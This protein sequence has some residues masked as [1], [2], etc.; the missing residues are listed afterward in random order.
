MLLESEIKHFAKEVGID[1]I[2]FTTAEPFEKTALHLKELLKSGYIPSHWKVAEFDS[3][4]NPKS[5]LP[6]AKSIIVAAECYLTSEPE[7][8]TKPGEPYGRIARYTWRNYYYDLKKRLEKVAKFLRKEVGK[9][10]KFKVYS[11]GAVAEKPM[12]QRSGLGWYG[13]HGIILTEEFGSRIVLG[14]IITNV[15][16]KPDELLEKDCGECVACIKSCPTGAIVNPAPLQ[17]CGVKLY[18]LDVSKCLQY[19]TNRRGVLPVEYREV[20]GNRLYG[21]TTCQDVCPKNAGVLP[22]ERKP[23]Y[24]E[25][26]SCLPLIPLL[27]MT[28][29]EYRTKY[30]NNQMTTRWIHFDCIKRNAVIALGNIGDSVAVPVL[31]EMLKDKNPMVRTHATWALEKI[32]KKRKVEL[33]RKN[34][35]VNS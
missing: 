19:L 27:E 6:E 15:E 32:I 22:K 21:C 34:S 28:E 3:F 30:K 10:S 23:K 1:V 16:L 20:W 29:E 24:G 2:R 35:G 7:D 33:I 17:R 26:G 5:V 11:C 18:I 13:K 9:Q 14:E 25:V 31:K 8:L 12:A 4:C